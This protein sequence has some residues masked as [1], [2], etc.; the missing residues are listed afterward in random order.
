MDDAK[1]EFSVLIVDDNELNRWVL[2]EQLQQ[3]SCFI[4]QAENGHNAL[5]LMQRQRFVI[6]FI[7]VNMPM[8]NGIDLIKAVRKDSVN[9]FTPMIAITAYSEQE[10]QRRLL[11]QGFDDYLIKPISLADL[12]A[13]VQTW[14]GFLSRRLCDDYASNLM[15][16]CEYNPNVA[17][18]MLQKLLDQVPL[19]L[20]ALNDAMISKDY[21]L[22]KVVAHR[23]H[24]TFCLYGFADFRALAL[25]LEQA[26]IDGDI[27]QAQAS[28]TM[29]VER[30][31]RLVSNQHEVVAQI[32]LKSDSM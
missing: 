14:A 13:V 11:E 23:M 30:V 8:M 21:S 16:K 17:G 31:Q 28:L 1:G 6:A 25:E 9:R 29:L 18:K 3:W 12:Q 22:A 7:D 26:F 5:T 2:A 15:A 10:Q 20:Q 32:G 4:A 27:P 19:E 24:G